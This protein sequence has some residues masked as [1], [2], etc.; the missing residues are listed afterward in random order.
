MTE[1]REELT[2]DEGVIGVR[3]LMQEEFEKK[4][5][6]GAPDNKDK[7]PGAKPHVT[8]HLTAEQLGVAEA[9]EEADEDEQAKEQEPKEEVSAAKPA[10]K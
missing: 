6:S 1:K 9:P 4:A 5:L 8:R 3:H 10:R 7:A 2:S